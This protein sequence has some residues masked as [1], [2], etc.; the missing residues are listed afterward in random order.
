MIVSGLSG[1]EIFCLNKVGFKPGEILV[2]NSVFSMG[3]AGSIASG[4]RGLV[5]GEITQYTQMIA[6]GRKLAVDRMEKEREMHGGIGI[7]GVT[8]ELVSHPGNIEFL[9]VASALQSSTHTTP[10]SSAADGQ[11][12]YCQIDAGY[13]PKKF[14][15][16]NV[17]YS[18]GVGQGLLGGIRTLARGE[19][20]EYTDIFN[21]TRNLALQRIVEDAR[22]AGANSVV[23]IETTI[24]PFV[25]SGAQEML[26]IGTASHNPNLQLPGTTEGTVPIADIITSDLT[27]EEMWNITQMG[28]VPYKVLLGTSVYSLGLAGGVKA[29]LRNFVKGEINELTTLIY[30]A[31]EK[32]ISKISQEAEAIGADGVLGVKT[33]IY[34]LGSGLIEF[35]AIG[36]AVKYVGAPITTKT[37]NL[38]PQAIIRDKDTFVNSAEM[39]FGT[40]LGNDR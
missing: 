17:A 34:S 8:S 20:T 27:C 12:L 13:E 24:V 7:T 30:D 14:V 32:S 10:F 37:E 22:S 4:F 5:G 15:F 40:D 33:Y 39:S 23:G 11:E 21:T 38:I 35:L 29:F 9:S 16:G 3:F 36:T 6:E 26:M 2:G 18:I 1:N 25:S 19:V 28:F 31:R